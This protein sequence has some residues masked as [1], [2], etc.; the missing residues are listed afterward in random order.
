MIVLLLLLSFSK[1]L[2]YIFIYK[3][4]DEKDSIIEKYTKMGFFSSAT[5]IFK[6]AKEND[7]KIVVYNFSSFIFFSVLFIFL[8]SDI[9]LVYLFVKCNRN[10]YFLL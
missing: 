2:I 9:K 1:N 6:E 10:L 7:K 4:I 8:I 3:D 5:K